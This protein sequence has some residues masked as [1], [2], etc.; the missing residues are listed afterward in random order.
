[1]KKNIRKWG[2]WVAQSVK[3]P[4]PGFSSGPDLT[5]R[6]FQP[7][8]GLWADSTE[9]ARDPLSFSLSAPPLLTLSLSQN[10]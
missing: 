6:E 1:M 8:V 10:K 9:L 5:V 7:R 3:H 2:A 4:T